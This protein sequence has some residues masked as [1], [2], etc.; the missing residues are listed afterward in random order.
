MDFIFSA[1]SR[2]GK[3][4]LFDSFFERNGSRIIKILGIIIKAPARQA[5]IDIITRNPKKRMGGKLEIKRTEN[6]MITRSEERRV[7][8]ECRSRWSPDH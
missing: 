1:R 6:P 7:G 4:F 5:V 3:N 8:K 2:P